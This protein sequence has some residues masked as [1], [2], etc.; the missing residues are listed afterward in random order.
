MLL[1]KNIKVCDSVGKTV[2]I[3]RV[4]KM[5]Y[6]VLKRGRNRNIF[7]KVSQEGNKSAYSLRCFWE[8]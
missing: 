5:L 1:R 4:Y 3:Q 2:Y 8:N 7:I 6:C